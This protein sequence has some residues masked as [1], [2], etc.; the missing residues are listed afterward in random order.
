MNKG[1]ITI[2]LITGFITNAVVA[3]AVMVLT[4]HFANDDVSVRCMD[5]LDGAVR[6]VVYEMENN[7]PL[8]KETWE[9]TKLSC[10]KFAKISPANMNEIS[11]TKGVEHASFIDFQIEYRRILSA[12]KW[13]NAVLTIA[14]V[15]VGFFFLFLMHSL[16]QDWKSN[17]DWLA[18]FKGDRLQS[19]NAAAKSSF[20]NVLLIAGTFFCVIQYSTVNHSTQSLKKTI[21]IPVTGSVDT[22]LAAP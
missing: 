12:R 16:Y 4:G 22:V 8:V 7:N 15:G 3:I 14:A 11:K 5:A 20:L 21:L 10:K 9:E 17:N 2:G 13:L 19:L 1:Q 6:S 18:I